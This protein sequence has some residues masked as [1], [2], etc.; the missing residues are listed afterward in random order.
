MLIS[1]VILQSCG[2][3]VPVSNLTSESEV[4]PQ[5]RNVKACQE[6]TR[7]FHKNTLTYGETRAPGPY[8]PVARCNKIVKSGQRAWF[9][10]ILQEPLWNITKVDICVMRNQNGSHF[11]AMGKTLDGELNR[12]KSN[13]DFNR[14]YPLWPMRGDLK[15]SNTGSKLNFSG[16]DGQGY[17]SLKYH[18]TF[19]NNQLTY[20][21][22]KN[23]NDLF[24]N[25][26]IECES[27]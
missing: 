3:E 25:F 22:V 27:I 11:L 9:G 6:N 24:A 17:Y 14:N 21:T 4:S 15:S 16:L 19:N 12:K 5:S 13:T 20:S 23:G 26:T 18:A 2:A 10:I 7:Y 1:T 8:V